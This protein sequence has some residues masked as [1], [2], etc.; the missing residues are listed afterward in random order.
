MCKYEPLT[1]GHGL[2]PNHDGSCTERDVPKKS[3]HVRVS[4]T[5]NFACCTIKGEHIAHTPCPS[6]PANMAEEEVA[7]VVAHNESGMCKAAFFAC[8]DALRA[9]GNGGGMCRAGF[10]LVTMHLALY[11]KLFFFAGDDAPRTVY[12]SRSR[13][14]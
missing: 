8:D 13:C 9:A 14:G 3:L 10:L 1:Q 7:A 12:P 4:C 11:A 6:I 2:N 5:L